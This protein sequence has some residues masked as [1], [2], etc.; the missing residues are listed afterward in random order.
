[1]SISTL[2][3]LKSAVN[4]FNA[5][6]LRPHGQISL[7]QQVQTIPGTQATWPSNEFP[8]VYVF[9]DFDGNINYIG[10]A[11]N[12]I[13]ARIAARFDTKW[14]S[15]TPESKE[16]FGILT[17]QLPKNVFFEASAIE[18]FLLRHLTTK[19]NQIGNSK[20]TTLTDV[21]RANFKKEK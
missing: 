13:G 6:H 5:N 21:R 9:I 10:K 15:K 4:D 16:C 17:I 14:N 20:N 19:F 1:M 11:S 12:N 7:T 3:D 2:S 18:E 8:G